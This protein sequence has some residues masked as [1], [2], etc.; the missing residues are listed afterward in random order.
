MSRLPM[1]PG[2]VLEDTGAIEREDRGDVTRPRTAGTP[3]KE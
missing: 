3:T 1:S 2:N